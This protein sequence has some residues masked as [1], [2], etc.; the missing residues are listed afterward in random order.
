MRAE[1]ISSIKK[2]I[3]FAEEEHIWLPEFQR[4]FVWDD[5]Q[6]KLLIDSL[7]HNYTISSV[8]IWEGNDELARR[9][10][11]GS[12]REIE[13][14]K[15]NSKKTITYLLDGQQRT[16]ALMA[17]F[18]EKPVYKA[19]NIK[20]KFS[21]ELYFDALYKGDDPELRFIYDYE[22][23]SDSLNEKVTLKGLNGQ[24]KIFEKY[25]GRFIRLKD[26]YRK[27][28][29][30]LFNAINNKEVYAKYEEILDKLNETILQKRL[31]VIEQQGH[32][33][34]VLEVFERINTQNTK[35][36]IFDIMVAKTYKIYSNEIFDL[37]T[38]IKII[39]YDGKIKN[40]YFKVKDEIEYEDISTDE[41]ID[42]SLMLF[43]LMIILKKKFIAK[44]ILKI[45]SNDLI[46]NLKNI[47][48]TFHYVLDILFTRYNIR[49]NEVK[50]F[51]PILKFVT[52][53]SVEN[54]NELDDN[55]KKSNFL[56][57]WFWNTL[58]YNRYPGA[59][60]E[61]IAND[62]EKIKK[63]KN[64]SQVLQNIVKERTRS[65]NNIRDSKNS[66]PIYF[67]VYYDN[68][69]QQIYSA[70]NLLLQKRNPKDFRKGIIPDKSTSTTYK[71]NEHH[72][73][74]VKSDIGKEIISEFENS[75]YPN[76][77]NNI[78][79]IAFLTEFT[80]KKIF[81]QNP[82]TYIYELEKEYKIENKLDEFHKIMRSQFI[83][84]DMINDLKNDGFKSFIFKRTK[85]FIKTIDELCEID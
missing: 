65:F 20:K 68:K 70:F 57:K 12:I 58:M 60:N 51:Q 43:L 2:L 18:T 52:A 56:D 27:N 77:I 84:E 32:L 14:P 62:Y 30:H 40:D 67:E 47:H 46:N 72:I 75:N 45:T 64:F 34:A 11:G 50:Y 6:I 23:I 22:I 25:G 53:Y 29:Q 16:S 13:I 63:T 19:N 37:R 42:E 82:S 83:T 33:E 3:E 39:N 4:P 69:N 15:S 55:I 36:N 78:A 31:N 28:F 17:I 9:R 44:E 48:K 73:F 61:R 5:S 21:I 10:I 35:L 66:K 85:L 1:T 79:N 80:N 59:Q 7:Y 38:F 26:V 8:L 54:S 81:K 76:I 49:K 24:E 71:L 74:P 41:Y